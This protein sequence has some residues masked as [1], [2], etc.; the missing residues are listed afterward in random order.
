MSTAYYVA[1]VCFGTFVIL[2]L[3][4]AILLSKMSSAESEQNFILDELTKYSF[5]MFEHD[6]ST[7]EQVDRLV[8]SVERKKYVAQFK[9]KRS[10]WKHHRD[11]KQMEGKS[12]GLFLP[13]NRFRIFCHKVV[14]W[15]GVVVYGSQ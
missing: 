11:K 4:V 2:N 12:L 13:T 5:K 1:V 3:F 15:C 6:V 9:D 10:K 14:H 7:V 8:M